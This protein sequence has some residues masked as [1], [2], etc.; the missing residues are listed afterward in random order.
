M[1][2][3]VVIADHS[4]MIGVKSPYRSLTVEEANRRRKLALSPDFATW[5]NVVDFRSITIV[6]PRSSM[7]L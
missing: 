5:L 7:E 4:S 2:L 1:T 3:D 6:L